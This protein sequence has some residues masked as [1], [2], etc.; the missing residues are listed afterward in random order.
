MPPA[1]EQVLLDHNEEG[2]DHEFF[3]VGA[4][5]VSPTGDLLAYAVDVVGDE[6]YDVRVRGFEDG[7]VLDDTVRQT[8]GSLAWSLDARHLFY[9]RVDD[10]WRPAPG[11]ASRGRHSRRG[12]RARPRG[13]RRA[14]LRR[15]GQLARRPPL[16]IAIGSKTTSEFRLLDADDP[17]GTPR[18]VA[19]RR[20]GVEYDIEPFGDQM[21]VTHNAN[22]VNFELAV[23]PGHEHVGRRLGAAGCHERRR[24]RHGRRGIRRLHRGVAAT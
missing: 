23:A 19:E 17:L 12:R 3:A 8:G 24:V 16:L 5:E 1:G 9:T 14:L 20:Q 18:V 13:D 11:V 15:G 7:V 10:A 6:R 21:L 22:R 4:S 2:R